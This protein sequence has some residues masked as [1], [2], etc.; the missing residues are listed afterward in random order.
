[1][2]TAVKLLLRP[3]NVA[4]FDSYLNEL[5]LHIFATFLS[6]IQIDEISKFHRK[7]TSTNDN[8]RESD[9]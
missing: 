3:Y 4:I 8:T 5:C 7:D 1:M 9:L 2:Y 6:Y